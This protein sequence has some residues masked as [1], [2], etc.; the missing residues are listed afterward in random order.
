MARGASQK[1]KGV[2][3]RGGLKGRGRL[4]VAWLIVVAM[5]LG[6]IGWMI[7]L[8]VNGNPEPTP[9]PQPPAVALVLPSHSEGAIGTTV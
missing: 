3:A 2:L 6:A 9:T 1:S 7:A 5:V 4:A 8:L